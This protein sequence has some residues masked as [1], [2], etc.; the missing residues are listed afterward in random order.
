MPASGEFAAEVKVLAVGLRQ[1]GAQG[2]DFLAVLLFELVD[3]IGKHVL[4]PALS[5]G[6]MC[7]RLLRIALLNWWRTFPT[8]LYYE[9]HE[10]FL[11][12]EVSVADW[13]ALQPLSVQGMRN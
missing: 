3:L 12:G 13:L 6:P 2:L 10:F 9:V 8:Y 1:G 5:L 4:A 7:S 11:F